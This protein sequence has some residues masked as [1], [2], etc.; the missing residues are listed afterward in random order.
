MNKKL[1]SECLRV[2]KFNNAS[3]LHPQWDCYK[4]Y[5]FVIQG[6]TIVDWGTNRKGD[7]I[8]ILGYPGHSKIHSEYDAFRKAKGLLDKSKSFQVIN[9]RLSKASTLKISKPCKC[10][11]AYLHSAGCDIVWYSTIDGFNKIKLSKVF[12]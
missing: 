9:I 7:A 2:A 11:A 10:C 5:S 3:H 4:H 8:V 1:I 12:K 6:D